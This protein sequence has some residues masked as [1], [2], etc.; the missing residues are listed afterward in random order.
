MSLRHDIGDHENEVTSLNGNG[1]YVEDGDYDSSSEGSVL[2]SDEE[3]K[4]DTSNVFEGE[5]DMFASEDED[6]SHHAPVPD[7]SDDDDMF[8][9]DGSDHINGTKRSKQV[10]FSNDTQTVYLQPTTSDLSFTNATELDSENEETTNDYYINAENFTTSS[11]QRTL[12]NKKQPKIEAFNMDQEERDGHF[13]NVGNYIANKSEGDVSDD[14]DKFQDEDSWARNYT[15]SDIRKAKL[16]QAKRVQDASERQRTTTSVN[17]DPIES[18]LASLIELLEP[19][20]T[21]MEALARLNAQHRKKNPTKKKK[22]R[23][24]LNKNQ[25][26]SSIIKDCISQI[27]NFCSILINEKGM[28]DEEVYDTTREEF[29]RKYQSKTGQEYRHTKLK[30][31]R[32]N[33]NDISSGNG[34]YQPEHEQVS[35]EEV[36]KEDDEDYG[37]KIWEFKWLNDEANIINGPFSSYE[38]NYWKQ[39]YFENNVEVRKVGDGEFKHIQ[40]MSFSEES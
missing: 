30:R 6:K 25:L 8:A 12:K 2:S 24:Q 37:E 28:D 5:D 17:I 32:E 23:R 40:E 9:S 39:N 19:V 34:I 15:K 13:D 20:E 22:N 7:D 27:T 18:T 4:L 35:N 3:N 1:A 16:A 10:K 14:L 33:D 38:M 26:D 21:P 31:S 29:M 11:Q 36:F